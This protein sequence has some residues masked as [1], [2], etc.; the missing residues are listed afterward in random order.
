MRMKP[1]W[2]RWLSWQMGKKHRA[3]PAKRAEWDFEQKARRLTADDVAI[4]CGANLGVYTALLARTGAR[5]YAFEPDPVAFA[6]LKKRCAAL[7]NVTLIPKAVGTAAGAATLYR[8]KDFA[9]DPEEKSQ[10]S[11]LLDFKPNIDPASGIAVELVDLVAFIKALDRPVSILKV[12]IEGAEFD[13]LQALIEAG[14]MDRI[15]AAFVETHD[16]KIPGLEAAGRRLRDTI[17]ARGLTS[18]NLDWR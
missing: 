8:L 18:I 6:R 7:P 13:L 3:S 14:C 4:D 5:V 16:H 11:S 9:T 17:A 10:S 2:L 1:Y 12:D 15:G